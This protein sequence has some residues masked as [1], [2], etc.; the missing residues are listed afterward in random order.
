MKGGAG[1]R[2]KPEKREKRLFEQAVKFGNPYVTFGQAGG[3]RI[4]EIIGSE[5]ISGGAGIAMAHRARRIPMATAIV[6]RSYGDS[7][8]AAA[9]SD[10]VVQLRGSAM[11]VTSP[12]VIEAAT[13]EAISEEELGGVDVHAEKTG[14]IDFVADSQDEVVAAVRAF[15]SYMPDSGHAVAPRLAAARRP[16][17][18]RNCAPWSRPSG[19]GATTCAR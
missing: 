11:A 13:G 12:L 18:P 17:R 8:F 15:M 10:F 2:R 6:G 19:D 7:S 14:Q 3:A 4:Q 5:L 9:C 16:D 1:S